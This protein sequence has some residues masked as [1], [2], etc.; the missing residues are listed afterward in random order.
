M[1]AEVVSFCR[2]A[3]AEILRLYGGETSV[4][5]KDDRSP[6]T[7]A[8]KASHQLLVRRLLALTPGIPVISEESASRPDPGSALNGQFWLVDPLDGTKEFLKRSG[9]FT[10]NVALI[11]NGQP[12]LGAVFAPVS[13]VAY[14]AQR[15][16]GSWRQQSGEEAV[17][18]H[19]RSS[20]V[21]QLRIVASKDHAGPE[22]Q[23]LLGRFPTAEI[24]SIGS[25]LKFCMVAEG[26][27]DFYPR[28]VGTMEWD[29]AAAQC[30]VEESGGS[31]LTLDGTPLSYGKRDWKNPPIL[32]VGD[33]GFDWRMSVKAVL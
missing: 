17:P 33:P 8:D 12:V 9:N 18:I 14:F 4:T 26:H 3:G 32:T 28:F 6:L 11:R 27:A 22:V 1:L 7:A 31:V 24:I 13:D 2:E 5:Y 30:V 19:T 25:S 16:S 10:V 23:A 20:V 21:Q 29:T 15:G